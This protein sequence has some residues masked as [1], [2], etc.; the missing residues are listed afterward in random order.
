MQEAK[1]VATDMGK[2]LAFA[3]SATFSWADLLEWDKL[4]SYV[5]KLEEAGVGPEGIST[6]IQR[7]SNAVSYACLEVPELAR[8]KEEATF[9]KDSLSS[10]RSTFCREKP[11]LEAERGL[12]LGCPTIRH[13][14]MTVKEF[15][16]MTP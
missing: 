5:V 14:W 6:K 11:R 2:Y 10:W 15:S 1:E 8:R 13:L 7:L 12:R 4:Q 3:G 9:I 16:I